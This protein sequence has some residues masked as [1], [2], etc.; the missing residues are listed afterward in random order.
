VWYIIKSFLDINERCEIS[1]SSGLKLCS[2]LQLCSYSP[3][4][5][6]GKPFALLTICFAVPNVHLFCLQ[7]S[8]LMINKMSAN[9]YETSLN[10]VHIYVVIFKQQL[11]NS[12]CEEWTHTSWSSITCCCVTTGED[13]KPIIVHISRNIFISI[14]TNTAPLFIVTWLGGRKIW[15]FISIILLNLYHNSLSP[16]SGAEFKKA[17]CYDSTPPYVFMAGYLVKNRCK[18]NFNFIKVMIMWP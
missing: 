12:L 3:V 6:S 5:I 11:C 16:P 18:F 4:F 9:S 8:K 13:F 14:I 17:W 1:P 15:N 2:Q 10:C 7:L